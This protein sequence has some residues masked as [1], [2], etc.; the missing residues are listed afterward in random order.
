MTNLRHEYLVRKN[1]ESPTFVL[2][3]THKID[4]VLQFKENLSYKRGK[5]S[6]NVPIKSPTI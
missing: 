2:N 5:M 6:L 3:F 4:E 1:V